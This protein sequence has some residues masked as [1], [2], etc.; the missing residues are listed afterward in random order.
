MRELHQSGAVEQQPDDGGA[1]A[2]AQYH[3]PILRSHGE[4][5]D[6]TA[7]KSAEIKH[8]DVAIKENLVAIAW[9]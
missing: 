4:L 9:D 5:R 2:R 1:T 6:V 3:V 7:Q 8:S